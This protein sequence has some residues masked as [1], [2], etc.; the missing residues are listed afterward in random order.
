M[1]EMKLSEYKENKMQDPEFAE[2][3]NKMKEMTGGY[4]DRELALSLPFANGHYDHENANEH[5]IF[6]CETYKEWLET[7]PVVDAVEVVRCKDCIHNPHNTADDVCPFVDED[8]Y[9]KHFPKDGDFCSMGE[10]RDDG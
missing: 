2:E 3:Y 10:R 6:G 9:V 5:F 4:I 8:G 1:N 7:L